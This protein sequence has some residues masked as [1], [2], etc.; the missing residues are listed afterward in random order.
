MKTGPIQRWN[1]VHSITS[2]IRF[3]RLFLYDYGIHVVLL[4]NVYDIHET[5]ESFY[6]DVLLSCTW[7]KVIEYLI[8][9]Q[10]KYV[11]SINTSD[12]IY[13]VPLYIIDHMI[14]L[15][16]E[17]KQIK[18]TFL[19]SLNANISINHWLVNECPLRLSYNAN[20]HLLY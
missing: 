9:R 2:A 15:S 11:E 13:S 19:N 16:F 12:G 1:W 7:G 10:G 18:M 5:L 3:G 8:F 20:N 17:W 14:L 6:Y 4:I